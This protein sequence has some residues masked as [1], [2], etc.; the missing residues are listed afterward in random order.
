MMKYHF[1]IHNDP[2]GLWAQ[3]L[4]LPGC[5]TQGDT[6]EELQQGMKEVINLAI[7]ELEDSKYLAP[8]PDESVMCTENVVEVSLDPKIALS[9]LLRYY[10]ITQGL[11]QQEVADKM[12]F[13]SL[14]SYQ[15]LEKGNT[16]PTLT[17]IIKIKNTFPD[18]SVDYITGG[19]KPKELLNRGKSQ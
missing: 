5:F 2:D 7:E 17:T 8:F 11:T 13:D 18:L 19:A 14:H 16:N 15:R 10:R 4:E 12:G 9:F 1:E 6:F 3:C